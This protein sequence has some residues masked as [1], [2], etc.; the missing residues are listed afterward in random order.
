M[1]VVS[2]LLEL[3]GNH[4]LVLDLAERLDDG[5]ELH[6]AATHLP[7][8]AGLGRGGLVLDMDVIDPFYLTYEMAFEELEAKSI[9][10][11]NELCKLTE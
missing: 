2:V 6:H 11:A 3:D 4:A 1:R 5:L 9:N 10:M 8:L 7:G